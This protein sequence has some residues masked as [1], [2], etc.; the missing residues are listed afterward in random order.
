MPKIKNYK[1]FIRENIDKT[2]GLLVL[3]PKENFS[4]FDL[5]NMLLYIQDY[6]SLSSKRRNQNKAARKLKKL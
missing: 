6:S 1:K 3:D 5:E 2:I 4:S